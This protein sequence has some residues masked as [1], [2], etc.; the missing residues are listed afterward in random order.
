MT[1]QTRITVGGRTRRAAVVMAVLALLAGFLALGAGP[2]DAASTGDLVGVGHHTTVVG[3]LGDGP[4]TDFYAGEL[5]LAIDGGDVEIAYCIDL[6]TEITIGEDDL[7]ETP[8]ATSGIARLDEVSYILHTYTASSDALV[9]TLDQ[10]AAA[11]QA[12]IWTLTDG[13]ELRPGANP[14]E[15]VTSYATIMAS[16]PAEGLPVEPAPSLEITPATAHATVGE[17]AGPFTVHTTATGDVP[18]TVTGGEV[19]E[20]TSGLPIT[21]AVDGTQFG[22][23]A[24]S[25]GGA[26]VTASV[27]ATVHAGRVF[28]KLDPQGQ[29][30]VQRL[31]LASTSEATTS[32]EVSATFEAPTTTTE[33]VTTTTELVTTTTEQ[34][35]TTTEQVTTTTEQVSPTTVVQTTTTAAP[36][37]TTTAEVLGVTV[38]R[39]LPRT[40]RSTDVLVGV[41]LVAVLAGAVLLAVRDHRTAR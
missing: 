4:W 6:Q 36:A 41:G 17:V 27:T 30:L 11:I 1:R 35:T 13:F 9:G 7:V 38:Q 23:R 25:E 18:L 15:I 3:R 21:T 32:A 26:T 20:W 39:D 12:A 10:R 14:P 33:Q 2:A 28:A 22:V 19:V 8:W 5:L 16:I 24:A 29:P 31:I 40:G 37:T 34:V